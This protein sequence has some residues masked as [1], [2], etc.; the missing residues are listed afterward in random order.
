MPQKLLL[1]VVRSFSIGLCYIPFD[2]AI[3]LQNWGF[4]GV[5]E[6]KANTS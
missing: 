4:D 3:D 6:I 5:C 1:G 2:D